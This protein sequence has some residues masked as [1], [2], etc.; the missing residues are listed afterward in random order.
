MPYFKVLLN[1]TGISMATGQNTCIGFFTTRV[2]RAPS[3]REAASRAIENILAEWARP[4]YCEANQGV[5]PALA[6]QSVTRSTLAGL[7]T[8]PR[9]GYTFYASE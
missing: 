7:L 1:G 9:K 6:I 5:A 2:V 3:E 4:P 8:A